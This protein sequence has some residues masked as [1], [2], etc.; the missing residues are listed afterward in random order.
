MFF[1]ESLTAKELANKEKQ[2]KLEDR[3]KRKERKLK[4]K[5]KIEQ[6]CFAEKMNCF[7]HDNDHWRTSP[8][9]TQGRFCLCM[10]SNNNSYS[11]LRT[12]NATHNF[13]YCE[14]VTGFITFFNL[15]IDPFEQWNRAPSLSEQEKTWLHV[16]LE[17]LKSCK[18]SRECHLGATVSSSIVNT[19]SNESCVDCHLRRNKQAHRTV[20]R[21][22]F[23]WV[24][25]HRPNEVSSQ[26]PH[27]TCLFILKLT[28]LVHWN[29][30]CLP[31]TGIISKPSY[32]NQPRES[33]QVFEFSSFR[34]WKKPFSKKKKKSITSVQ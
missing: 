13:L 3:L 29:W 22:F 27:W 14:F 15:R 21:T 11:C 26:K 32:L 23:E 25:V 1:R 7:I 17:S 2:R 31:I 10:N 6:E 9:W 24:I 5:L 8:F 19:P 18:G 28:Y 4:K 12:I 20:L 33:V 34:D 16:S 30:F